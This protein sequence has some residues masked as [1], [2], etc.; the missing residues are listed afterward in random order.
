[1]ES[2]GQQLRQARLRLGVSLEDISAKTRL[3]LKNL[4]AIENDDTSAISAPFFYKSFVRQFAAAVRVDFDELAPAVDAVIQLMPVPL[5]PG[6]DRSL[7]LPKIETYPTRPPRSFRWLSSL[8][9]LGL[10]L[11]ACSGV[12]ALWQDAKATGNNPLMSLLRQLPQVQGPVVRTTSAAS[13]SRVPLVVSEPADGSNQPVVTA[14][15]A[16]FHLELSALERTW[17]SIVADGRETFSGILDAAETKVLEG[18]ETAKIR[19]GNAGGL[20]L[21][22]NGKLLGSLGARGQVRTVVFTRDRYEIIAEP[23][24]IALIE[25]APPVNAE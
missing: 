12:Y 16:E 24:R 1:M 21:I 8:G 3:S 13:A 15:T 22:F 18:H 9:S 19:T 4:V 20:R 2:V 7:S 14:G 10:M 25:Y 17:L 23:S 11:V 5:M 6:Q